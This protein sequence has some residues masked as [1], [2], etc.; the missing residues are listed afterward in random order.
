[1]ILRTRE[2]ILDTSKGKLVDSFPWPPSVGD[3]GD[4]DMQTERE[5]RR[6]IISIRDTGRWVL[7]SLPHT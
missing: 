3:C 2:I 7:L 4:D 6:V 5:V 1:M